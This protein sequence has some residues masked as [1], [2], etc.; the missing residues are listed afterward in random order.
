M[1]FLSRFCASAIVVLVTVCG[2]QAAALLL[3]EANALLRIDSTNPSIVQSRTAVTGLAAGDTLMA[4]AFRPA[5]G[6]L[7]GLTAAGRIYLINPNTGATAQ[8][9]SQPLNLVLTGGFRQVLAFTFDP[10]S[11]LIRVITT[12]QNLRVNPDTGS[13]TADTPIAF[14]SSDPNAGSD[15]LTIYSA[16]YSNNFAGAGTTTLYATIMNLHNLGAP[17]LTTQGSPGGSPVSPNTG[18][19]FTIGPLTPFA[20]EL[21]FVAVLAISSDG[22]NYFLVNDEEGIELFTVN[23]ANAATTLIGPVSGCLTCADTPVSMTVVPPNSVA[24]TGTFQ[25]SAPAYSVNKNGGSVTLTVTRTGDLSGPATVDF[26]SSDGSGVQRRDYIMAAGRLSFGPGEFSKTCRVLIV[27]NGYPDASTTFSVSLTQATGGFTTGTQ[28]QT[29]VSIVN[30]DV[31]NPASNPID[32]PEFFVRQQYLDFLNRRPDPG[33][34]AFWTGRITSC[35]TDNACIQRQ[36]ITVSAAFVFSREFTETGSFVNRVNAAAFGFNSGPFNYGRFTMD[37]NRIIA[38]ADLNAGQSAFVDEFVTRT[39]FRL[40]LPE[41]A[42]LYVDRLSVNAGFVLTQAEKDA[43]VQGLIN[44]TETRATVLSKVADNPIFRQAIFN[45]IFVRMQ[46]F[47][48]LRRNF[49]LNGFNFWLDHINHTN[50]V[51]SMVCAFLTS[52]EYQERFSSV[53][54]HSNQECGP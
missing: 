1:R 28:N 7:Y 42:P 12:N 31:V 34:L 25:F 21:P 6:Q 22:T 23:L 18:Q 26:L 37:R 3:L 14:A 17:L 10:V 44:G 39:L 4:I 32:D 45:R 24:P 49:D 27:D 36:R 29:V 46:Y 50:N 40:F 5:T 2:A 8:V 11:D 20:D 53:V 13:F 43:L 16:A 38:G 48:Y 33:G 41:P 30:N 9:G 51:N 15:T 47:G 35:G 52:R 19:Q 54:T